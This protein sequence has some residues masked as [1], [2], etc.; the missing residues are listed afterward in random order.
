MYRNILILISLLFTAAGL[1]SQK[2]MSLSEAIDYAMANHP[3][4]RIAQLNVKD[5]EWQIKENKATGLPNVSLGINYS[6]FIQQPAL[7]A[8]ALGFPGE[9]GQKLTFALR[10][11]LAG[12]IGVNQLI[13]NNSY[14]VALKAAKL[15]REYAGL[16]LE[17]AKEKVRREVRDAYLPA[18]LLSETVAV[19]DSNIITQGTVLEETRAI[20]K[21][22][23]V[24]QLDVDRLDLVASTL[25]TERESLLRQRDMLIDVFKFTINMPVNEEIVLSDDLDRL[26]DLYADIN[27]DEQL[28][29]NARPDYV[30]VQKLKQLNQMNVQLYDKDWLPTV[31]IFASYDPSFQGNQ[32]LFWIPSAIAGVSISM[33]IYD[34]GLSKAKQ[35]RAIIAA[36]QVDE[37]SDMLLRSF[38]LE[39]ENARNQYRTAIQI[40]KDQERNLAL[41]QRIHN[42]SQIKFKSGIGSSFEVSQ[43]Q[44]ALYQT[45]GALVQARFELLQSIVAF[46]KA[47]GK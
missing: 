42:T 41:A 20:Y 43:A 37:Q 10:N 38:D 12:K 40:V 11:N 36:M 46:N 32:K 7:P 18:L 27:I 23:F 5:A 30:T 1:Q 45:Q 16:Q 34:G 33:P 19:L 24:E 25:M 47:L 35:E 31:S 9:P 6:Y 22:G 26:L 15:Y 21:A 3:E 39:I 28:D 2:S 8:E 44:S 13:F 14:L 29:P 17:A 4:I